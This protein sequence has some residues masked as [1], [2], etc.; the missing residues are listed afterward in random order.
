MYI[1]HQ[2]AYNDDSAWDCDRDYFLK[3]FISENILK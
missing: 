1:T 3:Y 2:Q